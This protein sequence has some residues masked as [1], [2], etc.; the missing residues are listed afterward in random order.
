MGIFIRIVNALFYPLFLPFEGVRPDYALL[1]ISAVT[2]VAMLYLYKWTS[3]QDR[4]RAVQSRI[5]AHILEIQLYKTDLSIMLRSL[6][7][8]FMRNLTYMRLLLLPALGLIALVVVLVVQCYPRFQFRPVPPGGKV[9]VKAVLKEW[10]PGMGKEVSLFASEGLLV[11]SAP[12]AIP[13]SREVAWRVIPKAEGSY[14]LTFTVDGESVKRK[15]VSG[16]GLIGVSPDRSSLSF[17]GYLENPMEIPLAS[18]SAF[19]KITIAYP[20]RSMNQP[21]L[22]GMNWIIYFFVVSFVVALVWKFV[23]RVH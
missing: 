2:G 10:G 12:L 22:L 5:K 11:D 1:I 19:E 17:A 13:S 3:N 18:G 8:V 15:L 7:R 6:F 9:L 16:N 21:L 20:E 4:L 14:E 23:A